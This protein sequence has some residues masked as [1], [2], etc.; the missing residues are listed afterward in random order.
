MAEAREKGVTDPGQRFDAGVRAFLHGS[1]QRRDL[2]LLFSSGDA[3]PGFEIAKRHRYREWIS[4]ND[5]LPQL[6]D[7]PVD[8]VYAAILTSLIGEG[9]REVAGATSRRQAEMIIDAVIQYTRRL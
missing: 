4:R 3:P 1:W 8:R 6:S 7:T 5:S 9:A 2:A